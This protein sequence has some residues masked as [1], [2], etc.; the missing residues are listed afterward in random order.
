MYLINGHD[1][2]HTIKSSYINQKIENKLI[3]IVLIAILTS[4]V[5]L[6]VHFLAESTLH[7]FVS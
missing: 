6:Q 3:E 4:V 7:L 2:R 5:A 1:L